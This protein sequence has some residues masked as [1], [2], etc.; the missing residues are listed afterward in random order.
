MSIFRLNSSA[1]LGQRAIAFERL[2]SLFVPVW[3]PTTR[4]QLRGY[5]EGSR[6]AQ[7]PEHAFDN[8]SASPEGKRA[9]SAIP[10]SRA[11]VLDIGMMD[12]HILEKNFCKQHR[13]YC[14]SLGGAIGKCWHIRDVDKLGL[15]GQHRQ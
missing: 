1:L 11:D 14:S 9:H 4:F 15:F 7:R 13:V 12:W 5:Y 8:A 6:N 3:R 2:A 10:W